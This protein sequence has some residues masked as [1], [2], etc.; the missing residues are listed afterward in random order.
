MSSVSSLP[1][2][3][4]ASIF[5]ACVALNMCLPDDS[6][7]LPAILSDIDAILTNDFNDTQDQEKRFYNKLLELQTEF[8]TKVKGSNKFEVV[9]AETSLE[10]ES[11]LFV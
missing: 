3:S 7:S 9:H 4:V 6:L 8:I 11:F 2:F 10:D 1:H 5:T